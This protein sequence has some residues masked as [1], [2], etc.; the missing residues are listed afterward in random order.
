MADFSVNPNH[1]IT[2]LE[3][4]QSSTQMLYEKLLLIEEE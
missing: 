3:K 2:E 4:E 1:M